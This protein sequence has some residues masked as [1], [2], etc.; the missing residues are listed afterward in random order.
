MSRTHP[1][2]MILT[3]EPSGDFHAGPLIKAL[4]QLRPGVTVSGIGG[5]A[6]EAQGADIFS[7]LL[8]SLQWAWFRLSSSLAL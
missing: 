3:G 2:I 7:P 1:H 4:K 8:N 6:M 5:P